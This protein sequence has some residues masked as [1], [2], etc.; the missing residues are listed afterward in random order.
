MTRDER[1]IGRNRGPHP[2]V[3]AALSVIW[4]GLGHFGHRNRRALIL[5]LSSLVISCVLVV[6]VA[7]RSRST[8]LTWTVAQTPLWI[9]IIIAGLGLVFRIWVAVDAYMVAHGWPQPRVRS[10]R[11]HRAIAAATFVVLAA[12]IAV[13]HFFVVRYAVAQLDLLYNVFS[14]TTTVTATPTPLVEESSEQDSPV[15]D[16]TD[17]GSVA[18]SSTRPPDTTVRRGTWDGQERLTIA[19][20]GSDSGF[21]RVGVRTDT[22]ILISIDVDT[23]DAAAFNIPRNW[24]D[25]TFPEGAPAAE[26]WPDGYMG[27]ANEV[28]SLGLRYPD[29]FPDVSDP[30][31]HAIKSAVAQLTGIPVQYYVLI[32]MVGFIEVVDLFGGIDLRVSEEINDRLKPAVRGGEPMDIVVEPGNYRF[33]GLTALAYVRARTQS[34]DYH[35]MTRQRCVVEALIKQ[36]SIPAVLANFVS[37]TEIISS[38]VQTDIPLDRVDELVGVARKL[39]TSRIVTVNFI[40]PEFPSGS[41]PTPLVREAVAEALAGV[42]NEANA[43]LS[44][45]CR[46]PE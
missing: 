1:P 10:R 33:D 40:P 28:Y 12:L 37:L 21:D 26:Q 30:A 31:G 42:A 4:P 44:E 32:D 6:Y 45:T 20:L 25:L 35:R 39:D 23:G 8:L 17:Q 7:T 18:S 11:T 2:L 34:S 29:I 15:R 14:A 41:V 19:L 27:I 24:R 38:H 16:S 13:P 43:A 5:L 22:I 3:A 46:N 36:V 9:T